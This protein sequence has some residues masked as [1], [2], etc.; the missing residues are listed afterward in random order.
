MA[1][2]PPNRPED[3]SRAMKEGSSLFQPKGQ[4]RLISTKNLHRKA[5]TYSWCTDSSEKKKEATEDST[6][7]KNYGKTM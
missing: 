6:E 7:R 2:I 1:P 5:L 3:G 4:E